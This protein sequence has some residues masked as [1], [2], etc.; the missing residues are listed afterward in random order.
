MPLVSSEQF[1]GRIARGNPII[2]YR[3]GNP[4]SLG[5]AYAN[6]A[7]MLDERMLMYGDQ[8]R[9]YQV[10]SAAEGERRSSRR[11]AGPVTYRHEARFSVKG[12]VADSWA[13]TAKPATH[14]Q[15]SR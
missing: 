3:G 14:R 4:L 7:A 12:H 8:V 13:Q 6:V 1:L 15:G 11:E 9:Q 2:F 5:E 10:T